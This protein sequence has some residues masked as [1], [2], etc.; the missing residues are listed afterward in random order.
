MS[1]WFAEADVRT[2]STVSIAVL[3][4]MLTLG[5]H[6]LGEKP[7]PTP[8]VMTSAVF[9]VAGVGVTQAT[10]IGLVGTI[11]LAV[12]IT[13]LLN[14]TR[15]GVQ[16]RALSERATTAELLGIRSRLL[17][18][19]VWATSGVIA[20]LAMMVIGAQRTA[21]FGTLSLLVIPAFAAALFGL[22]RN[23]YLTVAGG[24]LIGV[25]TDLS[26]RSSALDTYHDAIPL[27]FIVIAMLW[28]QRA[29]VWDAAR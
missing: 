8:S 24:L 1:L 25:V 10:V 19:G 7:R 9:H 11:I 2:R 13:L 29:E 4:A 14:R 15:L 20:V 26:T 27:V 18:L 12:G 28:S 22:F 23:L 16:L 17:A 5:F 21:D 6:A 3:V